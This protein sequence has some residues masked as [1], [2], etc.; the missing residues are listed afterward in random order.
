LIEDLRNLFERKVDVVSERA[1]NPLLQ[2]I[3]NSEALSL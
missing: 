1:V 2:Q 3:I